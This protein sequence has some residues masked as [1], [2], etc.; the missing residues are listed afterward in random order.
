MD[1]SE[2]DS[3]QPAYEEGG[4]K[5][6]NVKRGLPDGDKQFGKASKMPQDNYTMKTTK[7]VKSG[8]HHSRH[9]EYR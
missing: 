3:V 2:Y 1:S 4:P 7:A 8:V 6:I 5:E 9:K